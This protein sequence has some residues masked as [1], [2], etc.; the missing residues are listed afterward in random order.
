M[1]TSRTAMIEALQGFT[2]ETPLM[3]GA[4]QGDVL[5]MR[6]QKVSGDLALI[7]A[8]SILMEVASRDEMDSSELIPIIMALATITGQQPV[9]VDEEG[10]Q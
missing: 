3:L 8:Q 1:N 7:F 4:L 2:D 5:M 10:M 9:R 6:A